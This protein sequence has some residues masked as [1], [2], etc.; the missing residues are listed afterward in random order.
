MLFGASFFLT[1][2]CGNTVLNLFM[3]TTSHTDGHPWTIVANNF[4]E[5]KTAES[6]A[7]PRSVKAYALLG[8]NFKTERWSQFVTTRP[9]LFFSGFR[10][11]GWAWRNFGV[12]PRRGP[13][14]AM[15]K[16]IAPIPPGPAP[17]RSHWAH[18]SPKFLFGPAS[19]S[20]T[21]NCWKILIFV[22]INPNQW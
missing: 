15:T 4:G 5:C 6:I 21:L 16:V 9:I 20:E 12:R 11:R 7:T 14:V 22:K 17:L 8:E 19:A 13:L 2:Y 10:Y 3:I 18:F 1:F